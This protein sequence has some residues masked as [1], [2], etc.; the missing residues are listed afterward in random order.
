MDGRFRASEALA[1]A[2]GAED[3]VYAV[4]LA[5]RD[6]ELGFYA[7]AGIDRQSPHTRDEIYFVCSGSGSFVIDGE[8]R[9]FRTGDALFVPARVPHSFRDFSRDFAA[10]VVFVGEEGG[11]DG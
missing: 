1:A 11:S 6:L 2:R 10:W 8:S 5:R 3:G 9:P 7:P 4:L